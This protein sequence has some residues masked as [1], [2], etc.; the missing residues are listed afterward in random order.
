[1]LIEWEFRSLYATHELQQFSLPA[2]G[3]DYVL[4][5]TV[6]EAEAAST[7]SWAG[8]PRAI[9]HL[10]ITWGKEG[11]ACRADNPEYWAC[12][13]LKLFLRMHLTLIAFDIE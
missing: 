12:G 10:P 2:A 9:C 7:G 11:P 8:M 3:L 4:A 6:N 1:M 13:S 5:A